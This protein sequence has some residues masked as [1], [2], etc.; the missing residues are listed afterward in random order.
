MRNGQVFVN[1][2]LD[3]FVSGFPG[4]YLCFLVCVI[5]CLSC[6]LGYVFVLC[7]L[8]AVFSMFHAFPGTV[9][10]GSFVTA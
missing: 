6:H 3:L 7:S 9:A 8:F 4:F 2:G 5:I 10:M 1:F